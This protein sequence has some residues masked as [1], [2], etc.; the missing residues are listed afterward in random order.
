MFKSIQLSCVLLSCVM[1]CFINNHLMFGQTDLLIRNLNINFHYVDI[2]SSVKDKDFWAAG[3][4]PIAP[5]PY[6]CCA[7]RR[8]WWPAPRSPAA[9]ST[10]CSWWRRLPAQSP[11][12]STPWR[13]ITTSSSPAL[14][15]PVQR[16]QARNQPPSGTAHHPSVC[17]PQPAP[18]GHLTHPQGRKQV[19]LH[20]LLLVGQRGRAMFPG[21]GCL[22]RW[23]KEPV[24]PGPPHPG[25]LARPTPHP[26]HLPSLLVGRWLDLWTPNNKHDPSKKKNTR[27]I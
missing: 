23:N 25:G 3:K 12:L 11:R 20:A 8:R 21:P 17:G 14:P 16:N 7:G 6:A 5:P 18:V 10:S 27:I 9:A 24:L 26:G 13:A 2:L 4:A 22:P 15:C 19:R 1:H